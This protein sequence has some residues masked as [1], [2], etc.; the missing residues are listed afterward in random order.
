MSATDACCQQ[1]ATALHHSRGQ[2][3]LWIADESP[4]D[5][6]TWQ[7]LAQAGVSFASNRYN[8]VAKAEQ[9]GLKA[10]F[11][12]FDLKP[13]PGRTWDAIYFRIA[14]EK[15]V[16]HKVVN[17]AA[18][19]LAP[20]GTLWLA[21]LKQEGMKSLLNKA[22]NYFGMA[23]RMH[24]A[25]HKVLLAELMLGRA[26]EPLDDQN[27][28]QLRQVETGPGQYF[29]S[30]P[31]L[32]G[33]QRVDRGSEFMVQEL[34]HLSLSGRSVLDLGCGYGYLSAS[35]AQL[36]AARICA[37]DNCAAA[38]AACERN[39]EPFATAV[40][41]QVVTSDCA[42]EIAQKFDLVICNPPF[43][44]GFS[45]GPQLHRRFLQS[46]RDHMAPGAEAWVVVNQ[47][48]RL[49]QLAGECG[50]QQLTRQRDG[51]NRFDLYRFALIQ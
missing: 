18:Q 48:I 7:Q 17:E 32:F 22:A 34:S 21:G 44:S 50:L 26:G 14:K 15:A 31:G 20:G 10:S 33:W 38:L 24:R 8:Q 36:G 47:F 51:D 23:P 29:W 40:P 5:E 37:T 9:Q 19:W 25:D 49:E 13:A 46:I 43:H 6:S 30:K 2:S 16:C 45:T 28:G 35:A 42:E 1:L 27:Y 12:D 41:A 4:I 3:A 11:C 39:L